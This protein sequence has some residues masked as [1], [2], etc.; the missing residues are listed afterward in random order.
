KRA[1]IALSALP[2]R[3]HID[4][5]ESGVG[6]ASCDDTTVNDAAALAGVVSCIGEHG[7]A[8]GDG[9]FKTWSKKVARK[10]VIAHYTHKKD[11]AALARTA[12]LVWRNAACAGE[13]SEAVFAVTKDATGALKVST[14]FT[15][16][17]FCGE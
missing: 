15:V 8:V 1:L 4:N 5:N 12:T 6:E 13:G 2:V 16:A 14:V 7:Y 3:A 11:V 17:I 9:D 10:S